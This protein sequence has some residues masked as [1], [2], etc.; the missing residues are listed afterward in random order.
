MVYTAKDSVSPT[1]NSL[2]RRK[3]RPAVFESYD[4]SVTAPPEYI[5][6]PK[7]RIKAILAV[8][9]M[10]VPEKIGRRIKNPVSLTRITIKISILLKKSV[11]KILFTIYSKPISKA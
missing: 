10:V 9:G 1:I 4:I 7:G 3:T 6:I 5:I 2:M 11:K 8:L